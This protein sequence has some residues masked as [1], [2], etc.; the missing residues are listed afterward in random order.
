MHYPSIIIAQTFPKIM[1]I[2]T[3]YEPG[4]TKIESLY[5]IIAI[6]FLGH[7]RTLESSWDSQLKQRNSFI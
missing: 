5:Y 2:P 1:L 6:S 3:L 4:D 7:P